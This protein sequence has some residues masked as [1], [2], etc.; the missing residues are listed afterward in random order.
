MTPTEQFM[1]A[2]ISEQ[3]AQRKAAGELHHKAKLRLRQLGNVETSV[4]EWEFVE[5]VAADASARAG[6][7]GGK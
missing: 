2:Y 6:K 1:T 4:G 5:A 7:D 3:T